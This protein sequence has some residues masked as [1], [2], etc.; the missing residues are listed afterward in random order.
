MKTLIAH[1]KIADEDLHFI[2]VNECYSDDGEP[3]TLF[4]HVNHYSAERDERAR[5]FFRSFEQAIEYCKQEYGIDPDEWKIQVRFIRDFQFEYSVTHIGVPQ[6]YP[7]GFEEGQVIFRID[8]EES[9]CG[10]KMKVLNICGNGSGLQ[11]LAALLLLCAEGE[12]YERFLHMHL[13]DEEGFLLDIPVT[14]RSPSYFE[15]MVRTDENQE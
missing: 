14:L 3:I 15:H 12:R 9:N 10:S 11:R 6:P 5:K 4:I 13:E 7:L 1:K 2:L 8:E